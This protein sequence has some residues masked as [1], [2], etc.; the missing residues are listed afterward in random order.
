MYF[1]SYCRLF[2]PVEGDVI[3][4]ASYHFAIIGPIYTPWNF[5][6]HRGVVEITVSLLANQLIV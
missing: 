1:D 4:Y 3:G 5:L 2:G 6:Y